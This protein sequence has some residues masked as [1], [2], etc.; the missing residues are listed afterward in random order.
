MKNKNLLKVIPTAPAQL[1]EE[2]L[3]DFTSGYVQRSIADLPKQGSK[4]P[5]K[6]YQNYILDIFNFRYS[7]FKD[8]AL[9]FS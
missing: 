2:P 6:L 5:W 9:N 7:S 1:K 8:D 4:K 3:L